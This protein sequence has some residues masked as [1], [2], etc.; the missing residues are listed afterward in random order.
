MPATFIK[1]RIT[2][3][4]FE[5]LQ[6]DPDDIL[7]QGSD[8]E[9]TLDGHEAKRRRVEK[10]GEE[11]LR[12]K[13]LY[14]ASAQLKGPF[15]TGWNSAFSIGRKA[16]DVKARSGETL[17]QPSHP[18]DRSAKAIRARSHPQDNP[19]EISTYGVEVLAPTHNASP[20]HRRP[21]G[22][23]VHV[24]V[25]TN[26]RPQA[27][28]TQ[29]P[30][31]PRTPQS[32]RVL[33]HQAAERA[34]DNQSQ[35]GAKQL[36]ESSV[37][38]AIEVLD[39]VE[40]HRGSPKL[41]K[42]KSKRSQR[43]YAVPPS[44]DL[45]G[46]VY[47]YG[48]REASFSPERISFEADLEARIRK[49]D[50]EQKRRLSFTASGS[51]KDRNPQVCSRGSRASN[52]S[53]PSSDAR[54][55]TEELMLPEAQVV[56]EPA[57]KAPSGPSTEMLETDKLSIQPLNAG[58]GDSYL[59]L[60]T[61]AAIFKAQKSLHRDLVSP[62]SNEIRSPRP[63]MRENP[64][65]Q[66]ADDHDN[67]NGCG[68]VEHP[69][70]K[71][72]LQT[73]RK[74]E[75][76]MSTQDMMNAISPFADTTIKR[77]RSPKRRPVPSPSDSDLSSPLSQAAPNFEAT[78]LSMSTS[79][80]STPT[81][82]NNEPSIPVS[83]LSKPTPITSFSIAPNGTLTEVFQQDGQQPE[84]DYLMADLDLDA[85]IEEAGS[86][87]GEWNLERETRN[88][89]RSTAVSKASTAKASRSHK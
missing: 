79:P 5:A 58:E 41:R 9:E 32:A 72:R 57:L 64:D 31:S 82:A 53:Q 11:Y 47:R 13:T 3:L 44:T 74:D 76:P 16:R 2:P 75:E 77:R 30:S 69:K 81:P 80:S 19:A 84:A 20:Y 28:G 12:G 48:Q 60:S 18:H 36:P 6:P 67:K 46:F 83:A 43:T 52:L 15:V 45:P 54:I 68:F 27:E 73:P 24:T 14:I 26:P 50:A 65:L 8:A 49:A 21:V 85:A 66:P 89:E 10:Y 4:R 37:S 29:A 1:R 63:W 78:T 39:E 86:F 40:G 59:G 23:A 70:P 25:A 34:Q 87:L 17:G 22:K 51:V 56:Q 35:H 71:P 55:S 42:P 88:F 38:E 33:S 7:C 62:T 61:Q